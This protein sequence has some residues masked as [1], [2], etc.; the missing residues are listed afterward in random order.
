MRGVSGVSMTQLWR[1][2]HS[3]LRLSISCA[4][5]PRGSPPTICLLLAPSALTS[6]P[7]ALA[8]EALEASFRR[9]GD[10]AL[11]RG[12]KLE[13]LTEALRPRP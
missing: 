13:K 5:R 10:R 1:S 11:P 3:T 7:F 9:L 2:A 6:A 12:R 4:F 8:A